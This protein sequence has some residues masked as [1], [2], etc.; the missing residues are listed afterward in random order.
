MPH[1]I[2]RCCSNEEHLLL[3]DPLGEIVGYA[4][5]EFAHLQESVERKSLRQENGFVAEMM[6]VAGQVNKR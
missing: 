6:E 4:I 5:V 3:L 2:Q 1:R